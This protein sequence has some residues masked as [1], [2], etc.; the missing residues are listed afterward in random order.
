MADNVGYTPGAG[1]TV[2]ADEIAGVLHQRVK[3]EFGEDGSATD[4]SPANPLPV[5]VAGEMMGAIESLRMAINSLTRTVGMSM[6]DTA[7]RLRVLAESATAANL[8]VT[9]S[10]AGG[11]T[12]Q[13]VSAVTVVNTVSNQGSMGGFAANDHIPAMMANNAGWIR[14]NINVT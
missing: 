8:L 10:I 7:G 6:P 3:I 4:V 5:D 14:N 9:A 13:A 11:Q 2:A 1:A 12:L